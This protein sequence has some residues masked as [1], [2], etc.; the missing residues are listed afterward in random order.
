[1]TGGTAKH[2]ALSKRTYGGTTPATTPGYASTGRSRGC[3]AASTGRHTRA[4]TRCSCSGGGLPQHGL[5][6]LRMAT[7]CRHLASPLG[8]AAQA[9]AQPAVH[10]PGRLVGGPSAVI[11]APHTLR[12]K[13]GV[14]LPFGPAHRSLAPFHPGRVS[15]ALPAWWPDRPP[16]RHRRPSRR[17]W[18]QRR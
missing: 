5:P 4:T 16:A 7:S 6:P 13:L 1:M 15:H 11:R 18:D 9:A 14:A 17:A 2:W 12:G 3:S 8:L 10:R